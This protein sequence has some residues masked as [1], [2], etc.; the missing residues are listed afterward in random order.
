MYITRDQNDLYLD[1]SMG[2]Q[3]RKSTVGAAKEMRPDC[4]CVGQPAEP[5][6]G[7]QQYAAH[8]AKTYLNLSS[9][10]AGSPPERTGTSTV[11]QQSTWTAC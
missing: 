8:V 11:K 9:V 2:M 10:V 1:Y 5:E 4:G 7:D 6:H 3:H